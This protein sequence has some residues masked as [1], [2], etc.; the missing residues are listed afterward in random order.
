MSEGNFWRGNLRGML[1]PFGFLQRIES[2]TALG[3]P[4][5]HYVLTLGQRTTSGWIELKELSEWPKREKTCVHLPHF[6]M[7]QAAWHAEYAGY[8]GLSF[9]LMRVAETRAMYLYP[10][11]FARKIQAGQTMAWHKAFGREFFGRKDTLGFVKC[12]VEVQDG[13]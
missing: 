7:A 13:T 11:T 8:G 1:S 5:L 10:G 9:I 6:T 12:L 3:I 2:S 4:D